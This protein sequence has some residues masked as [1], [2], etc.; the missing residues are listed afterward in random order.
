MDGVVSRG[1]VFW[2]SAWVEYAR[3]GLEF[4]KKLA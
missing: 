3:L 1:V 2:C 4:G